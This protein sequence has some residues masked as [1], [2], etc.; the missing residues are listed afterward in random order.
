MGDIS[1]QVGGLIY[2]ENGHALGADLEQTFTAKAKAAGLTDEEAKKRLQSE[3]DE[4]TIACQWT[5]GVRKA[6]E[7]PMVCDGL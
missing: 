1:R 5:C 2:L 7:S 4:R 3:H 6:M